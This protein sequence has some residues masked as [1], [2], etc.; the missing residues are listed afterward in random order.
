[1]VERGDV[2]ADT[3]P[4]MEEWLVSIRSCSQSRGLHPLYRGEWGAEDK[5]FIPTT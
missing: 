1:M 3:C 5:E 2:E 4:R